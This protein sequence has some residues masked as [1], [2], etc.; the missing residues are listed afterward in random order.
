MRVKAYL[1]LRPHGYYVY[2]T[3]SN[4]KYKGKTL[5]TK[6]KDEAKRRLAKF[7][8]ELEREIYLTWERD[9][10]Q[11]LNQVYAK[12][13]TE[14]E[15]N[16][17]MYEVEPPNE[18]ELEIMQLKEEIKRLKM[19]QSEMSNN[20]I[21]SSETIDPTVKEFYEE[22]IQWVKDNKR[23]STV[24]SYQTIWKEVLKYLKPKYVSDITEEKL[25]SM[26]RAMRD[27]GIMDKTIIGKISNLL[28]IFN[29]GLKQKLYTG[30]NP[31][32][33]ISEILNLKVEASPRVRSLSVNQ[34]STLIGI[35]K[36]QS[37]DMYLAIC[38]SGYSGL[39]KG[40]VANLR[41][42]DIDFESNHIDIR[43]KKLNLKK[44]IVAWKPKTNAGV[45]VINLLPE[46]KE[47][48][49]PYQKESGYVI[50]KISNRSQ[51]NLQNDFEAIRKEFNVPWF[52]FH[53]LR[54][55]F[56]TILFDQ[57]VKMKYVSMML[58]HESE[59]ITEKIYYHF[60]PDKALT[61]V[62]LSGNGK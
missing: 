31:V 10:Y 40:E 18:Y 25:L 44:G 23:A 39:R 8:E 49:L 30:P 46:L 55:T 4:G 33:G 57:G 19:G 22:V 29:I 7:K 16:P 21:P 32:K 50:E 51:W 54:H 1:V 3:D 41:W 62:N 12:E 58:G 47:I 5:K 24:S 28:M 13:I 61:G 37:R 15:K 60:D 34:L 45:R 56:V 36:N 35:A 9:R 43:D 59:S 6:N 17:G 52:S 14:Y 53:T 2:Y 38:I 48:L 26:F 20:V 42:E 27:K 11:Y